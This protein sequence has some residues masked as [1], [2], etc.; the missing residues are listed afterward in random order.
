MARLDGFLIEWLATL[1]TGGNLQV[2]TLYSSQVEFIVFVVF[3]SADSPADFNG[4]TIS[5]F[6]S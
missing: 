4:N 1:P 3:L 5:I 2:A 6:H